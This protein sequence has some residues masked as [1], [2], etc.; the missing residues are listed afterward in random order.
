MKKYNVEMRDGWLWPIKDSACWEWLQE[1]KDLP[2]R[3]FKKCKNNR[4]VVQAGGNCGFY[5]KKY[6]E[7]FDVVYTFEPDPQNFFCLSQNVENSNTIKIQ[8][9]LGDS[10]QLVGITHKKSNVGVGRVNGVG[11][12]PTFKI[13]DLNLE[14]CD[15][16]HLDVEGY[17][18]FAVKGAI[19]TIDRCSPVI[20]LEWLNHNQNYNVT[21]LNLLQLLTDLGYK[22]IGQIYHEKIFSK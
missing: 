6:A 2:E 10:H 4:V 11:V 3:I 7:L 22:E 17:E 16:I 8:G 20:A 9:C 12:F 18:L 14:H 13:D 21:E 15:L 5:V 1:E 19:E